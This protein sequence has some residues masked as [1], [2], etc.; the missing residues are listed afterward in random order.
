[1][2]IL[3]N[4]KAP[5][6]TNIA[7]FANFASLEFNPMFDNIIYENLPDTLREYCEKFGEGTRERDIFLLSSITV[8]SGC[9]SN[10]K[11]QYGNNEFFPNLFSFIVAP[12]ASGKGVMKYAKQLGEQ[13]NLD[14]LMKAKEKNNEL[15]LLG[16]QKL[17]EVFF[18]PGNSSSAAVMGHMNASKG[19]GV[20]CET[21]ADTVA[22]AF[23][24]DWGSYSDMLRKAFANEPISSSRKKNNEHLDVQQPKLA[25]SITGTPN[26]VSSLIHSADDGLFSRFM[27]YSFFE[28]Q[29]W[30][31]VSPS[32]NDNLCKYFH[33]ASF[34]IRAYKEHLDNY[35]T[36]VRLTE[37]QW[38]TL[39]CFFESLVKE[40]EGSNEYGTIFRLGTI[41]FKIVM[42]LTAL[43]KAETNS[44]DKE[45]FCQIQDLDISL[46]IVE[47]LLTHSNSV[48]QT[49]PKQVARNNANFRLQRFFEEFP[50]DTEL[51]RKECIE[52]GEKLGFKTRS[53]D[54]YLK[55]L[56]TGKQLIYSDYGFYRKA[57]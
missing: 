16:G 8:L 2:E 6:Q 51:E 24:N 55:Q 5:I 56:V 7:S 28:R 21:E 12:P 9:F 48:A 22:N 31:N 10:T 43:R 4:T 25:V 33:E 15:V 18:M 35:F 47:C 40:N 1:M 52:I 44:T 39:N 27:F 14:K 38:H 37:E 32:Q 49:L 19:C 41:A 34:K 53:I 42:V 11:G 36:E 50:E 29:A 54:G 20:I 30:K 46:S 45:L 57:S 13:I 3:I 26:Q 17:P 23:K